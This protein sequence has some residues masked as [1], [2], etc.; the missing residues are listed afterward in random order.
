MSLNQGNAQ[1]DSSA[2]HPE[3]DDV[4]EEEI[5]EQIRLQEAAASAAAAAAALVKSSAPTTSAY[6]SSRPTPAT[7]NTASS[8]TAAVDP[9]VQAVL[10]QQVW[11]T[12]DHCQRFEGVVVGLCDKL[13]VGK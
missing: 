8:P 3:L 1:H 9:L 4:N 7:A 11:I 5:Y 13:Q 12:M 6:A 10:L 2:A